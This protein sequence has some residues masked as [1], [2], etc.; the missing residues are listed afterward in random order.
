MRARPDHFEKPDQVLDI[1]VEAEAAGRERRVARIVP[2][3]DVDVVLG[4]H[5][6]DGVAQQ[7][8][9]VAGQRRDEQH[10]RLRAGDILGEM[11]QRAERRDVRRLLAHRQFLV[12]DRDGVDAVGRA[13]MG[14]SRARD[15]LVGR[16]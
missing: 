15:Q 9:E 11:Q 16:A 8:R 3:G 12:A 14:Q 10:A 5:R 7:R 13:H 2:V 6:L 4:Q 1:V